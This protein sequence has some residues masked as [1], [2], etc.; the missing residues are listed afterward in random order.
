MDQIT[1]TK[2]QFS[3]AVAKEVARVLESGDEAGVSAE[4]KVMT[5]ALVTAFGGAVMTR[6]FGK[7][8]NKDGSDS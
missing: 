6:L 2:D 7:E 8:E 4:A 1:I 3:D 5:M